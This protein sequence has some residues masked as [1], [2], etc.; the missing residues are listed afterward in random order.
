M[1]QQELAVL[2]RFGSMYDRTLANSAAEREM[3]Q[4]M[5]Q[6]ETGSRNV[7]NLIKGILGG[8]ALLLG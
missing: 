3:L 7:G 1:Q 5:A 8:A 2:D 4:A 6:Q